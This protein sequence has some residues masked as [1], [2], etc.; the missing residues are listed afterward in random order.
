MTGTRADNAP[1]VC[2]RTKTASPAGRIRVLFLTHSL[3]LGGAETQLAMVAGRLDRRRFDPSVLSFYGGGPLEAE[4]RDRGVSTNSVNKRGRTEVVGFV[5]R[6][7]VAIR[8]TKPHII[9]S[10]LTF[11]NVAAAMLR[12]AWPRAKL[13][14]GI[15]YAHVDLGRRDLSW[16]MMFALE[17]RLARRPDLVICNSRAGRQRILTHGVATNRV[18]VIYNGIDAIRFSPDPKAGHELRK[19]LELPHSALLIGLVARWDSLKD[20]ATFL[21]AASMLASKRPEARFLLVGRGIDSSNSELANLLR[22]NGIGDRTYMLGERTDVPRVMAAL[23][24]ATSSSLG[25]GFPNA[26]GEAMACGVPCVATDVGD[27]AHLIGDT[28]KLVA[29]A[30]PQAL[31]SAWKQFAH[32]TADERRV[33]GQAGRDRIVAKFTPDVMVQRTASCF[34][35]IL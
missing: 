19:E 24:I 9:F 18:E 12:P 17:K 25:E 35:R 21:R 20:H 13:I 8:R 27:C 26:V 22:E 23:D 29:P 4:L 16:R 2:C 14:W 7:A 1:E 31:A 33:L 11:P 28:G 5:A 15:R 30:A 10:F 32:L 34:E 3:Q 6:L